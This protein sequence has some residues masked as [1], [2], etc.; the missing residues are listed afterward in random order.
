M[1]SYPCTQLNTCSCYYYYSHAQK[2]HN[3]HFNT[4]ESMLS[5]NIAHVNF[6]EVL[7]TPQLNSEH[8][9]VSHNTNLDA[10]EYLHQPALLG[11]TWS[12]VKP[13]I[14]QQQPN[15]LTAFI[16]SRQMQDLLISSNYKA[17]IC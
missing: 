14:H 12:R 3:K 10:S 13:L 15:T 2:A 16:L 1:H 11:T 8:I 17:D 4:I 7:L 9:T 6:H 5:Q